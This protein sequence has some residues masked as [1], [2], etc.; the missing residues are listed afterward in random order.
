MRDRY[1]DVD[2]GDDE[3]RTLAAHLLLH[4]IEEIGKHAHRADCPCSEDRPHTGCRIY[5]E[6]RDWFAAD[7][8]GRVGAFRWCCDV[9]G[10]DAEAVR[11]R[12]R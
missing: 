1:D 12:V 9:L 4:A 11:R 10:L 2:Y 8:P 3:P 7:E 5:R 6:E